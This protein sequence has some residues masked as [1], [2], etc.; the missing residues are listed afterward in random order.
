MSRVQI[1]YYLL[2]ATATSQSTTAGGMWILAQGPTHSRLTEPR[3]LQR[4]RSG[5][6]KEIKQNACFVSTSVLLSGMNCLLK[7]TAM[8]PLPGDFTR[9]LKRTSK[10]IGKKMLNRW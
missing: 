5:G 6:F 9:S 8:V 10:P 3:G 1:V 2:S 4:N 7:S